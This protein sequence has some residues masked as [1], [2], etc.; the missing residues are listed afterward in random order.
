[1]AGWAHCGALLSLRGAA[2]QDPPLDPGLVVDDIACPTV[3]DDQLEVGE[4]FEHLPGKA[5]PLLGDDDDLVVG[6]LID[7]ALRRDRLAVDGD[8][9]IV[10]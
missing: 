4:T 10:G 3:A 5:R 6:Q 7:E 9:R 1:M 8:L 2:E